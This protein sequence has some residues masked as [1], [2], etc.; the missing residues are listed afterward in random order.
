MVTALLLGPDLSA[1]PLR[2]AGIVLAKAPTVE[3]GQSVAAVLS[4]IQD[5]DSA[6]AGGATMLTVASKALTEA[7]INHHT[8]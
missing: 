3:H 7:K 8:T 1:Y 6:V 2:A 4:L 5:L